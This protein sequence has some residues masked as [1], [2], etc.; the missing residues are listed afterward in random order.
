MVF[1]QQSTGVVMDRGYGFGR[2]VKPSLVT[3][4]V[5]LLALL[6]ASRLDAQVIRPEVP[7]LSLTGREGGYNPAYFPDGRLWVPAAVGNQPRYILVP[8]FIKN[9]W[10]TAGGYQARPI[11]SIRFKFQYDSSAFRAI[12]VQ[13]RGPV[14]SGSHPNVRIDGFD[15]PALAD[16]WQVSWNDA[17]DTLY[18]TYYNFIPV[19]NNRL[20]GRRVNVV[21]QS[22]QPLPL[23]GD[24]SLQDC[25]AFEYR[26][27]CYIKLEV[28]GRPGLLES[29]VTPLAIPPDS[30]Y[31]NTLNVVRETPFPG[32]ANYPVPGLANMDR[33]LAGMRYQRT[34]IEA[35]V[36]NDVDLGMLYTHIYNPGRFEFLPQPTGLDPNEIA[37]TN[38]NDG[39]S[40]FA[41]TRV[42]YLDP[43]LQGQAQARVRINVRLKPD[44]VRAKNVIVESDQPWLLFQGVA[45]GGGQF[46]QLNPTGVVRRATIGYIDRGILGPQG[47][48]F[49]DAV[50]NN[51]P[52][53]A[54]PLLNLDIVCDPNAIG[55]DDPNI[56]DPNE[57]AGKYEGYITFK[58]EDVEI[59]PVRV[60]VTFLYI[61][62]PDET[63]NGVSTV[64]APRGIEIKI[65]NSA[66]TPQQA[67]LLFGTGL[68]A[69]INADSLFGEFAHQTPPNNAQF[70][71][72]FFPINATDGSQDNGLGDYTG[73]FSS[74]DIRN[75]FDDTTIVYR[76]R[77]SAGGALN[78]P[79]VVTWDP[80]S[81]PDG[82]QL[83]LRDIEGGQLFAVNMREATE[84]PDG[85]R[86]YTIRDASVTAFDIEY[87]P[88][89]A[90]R[91]MTSD[92][93][94]NLVSLPVRPSSD[95]YSI[96][97]PNLQ[98]VT[99]IKFSQDIYQQEERLK[100]GVGYFVRFPNPD[101]TVISGVLVKQINSR[102]FP[103]RVYDG[104]NTVGA[105]SVPVNID[106]ITFEPATQGGTPPIRVPLT[107]IYEYQTNRGY[108]AVSELT[109]GKGYWIKVR[110][111][112]FYNV[113]AL[114]T[115]SNTDIDPLEQLA[116]TAARLLIGDAAQR[117][118]TLYLSEGRIPVEA[119][120][121]EMPPLPPHGMF[122][123]RFASNMLVANDVNAVV[124]VQGAE[125]PVTLRL[126]NS[127]AAYTVLDAVTGTFI[128]HLLPGSNLMISDANVTAVR[129]MRQTP[130]EVGYDVAVTPNPVD[131]TAH[132]HVTVPQ[133]QHAT[134]VLYNALGEEVMRLFDGTLTPGQTSFELNALS[135]PA[136]AYRVKVTSGTY[137]TV[138]PVTII[139]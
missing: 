95:V 118:G 62:V 61:R 67:R 13:T 75:V 125:Y 106:R 39:D 72:R 117:V 42:V 44:G 94:W 55:F 116:T 109:P 110:G 91:Q 119:G 130:Q 15:V 113:S 80:R 20:R 70:F 2:F 69:T 57:F 92:K 135:L 32:D 139:R 7:K 30:I 89:R 85:T 136:G 105:L 73:I 14:Y 22:N 46:K 66:P 43:V 34:G 31:Y 36:V 128:G 123:V 49:P 101:T 81:F 82:A 87:T 10:V 48:G 121:Y 100:V 103:V 60:K 27:L 63:Y 133:T 16:G 19:T 74:R 138:Q 129:L 5:V 78:Y 111:Q 56:Q 127:T 6:S 24:P 115:R 114:T 25:N 134:V 8:V 35:A 59:S 18:Q 4:V 122:D 84:N 104:W 53:N 68:R 88:A 64:W 12:G 137:T 1:P 108:R 126:A 124:R 50:N 23:T 9:C 131:A 52:P 29:D 28:K 98:G 99:P 120:Q 86:S 54:D 97:F 21:L 41:I 40:L 77:F 112:G 11:Y 107:F 37:V 93:G 79:V 58:S 38:I 17:R 47:I 83:F 45:A 90:V 71:A 132:V 102:L 96:V 26:P 33:Y 51:Q 76:V 3:V 65:R